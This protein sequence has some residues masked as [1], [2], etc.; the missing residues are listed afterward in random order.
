[1][2]IIG[3]RKYG[4]P[5]LEATLVLSKLLGVDKVY[6]YTHGKEKVSP[7]VKEKFIKLMEKKGYRISNTVYIER[8]RVYG[9]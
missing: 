1:M 8:K 7:S 5:Q 6:I 9:S 3:E 4:N 2:E